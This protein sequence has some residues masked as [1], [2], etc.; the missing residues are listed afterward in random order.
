MYL[1]YL[2]MYLHY[3]LINHIHVCIFCFLQLKGIIYSKQR[4]IQA[5]ISINVTLN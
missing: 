3:F 1:S 5:G 4:H 2:F